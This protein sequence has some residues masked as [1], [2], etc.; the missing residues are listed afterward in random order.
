M[1]AK[2]KYR[3]AVA[4]GAGFWG[5]FYLRAFTL[6]PDCEIIALVETSMERREKFAAEYNIPAIYDSVEDLL[7]VET[8]DI[9]SLVLPVSVTYGAVLACADAGVPVIAC[10]KPLSESLEK[11]DEMVEICRQK[12]LSFICGTALWE[13]MHLDKVRGWIDEGHIGEIKSASLFYGIA[14]YASGNGCVPLNF[15]RYSTGMEAKWV[16]GGKTWPPEAA[17]T[18][19]DCGV[20]GTIGLSGGITCIIPE[21]DQLD[22]DKSGILL[23]GTKGHILVKGPKPQFTIGVGSTAKEV[24]PSFYDDIGDEEQFNWLFRK[25]VESMIRIREKG[26]EALCSGHDYRQVLEIAIAFKLSAK[27]GGKRIQLPLAERDHIIQPAAWRMVGGD[28]AG[29]VGTCTPKIAK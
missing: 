12:G 18:D 26:G 23:E 6:N 7:K 13:I 17:D 20:S 1:S 21:P 19:E 3:V 11:A 15:L 29:W 8:P 24:V 9:V 16:E 10:E 14:V 22:P 4:G 2:R 25:A 5:A 28:I 27:A